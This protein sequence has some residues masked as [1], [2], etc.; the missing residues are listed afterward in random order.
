MNKNAINPALGSRRLSRF[1]I[2]AHASVWN[3]YKALALR[4]ETPPAKS[5]D[6]EIRYER[7]F[8]ESWMNIYRYLKSHTLSE[9]IYD[10]EMALKIFNISDNFILLLLLKEFS[11]LV[12]GEFKSCVYFW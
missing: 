11:L 2:L 1:N 9:L 12:S 6:E 8:H 3:I 7:I 10:F 4:S 5:M